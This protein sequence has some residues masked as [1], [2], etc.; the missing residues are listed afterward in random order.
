MIKK[1]SISEL[2]TGMY[3]LLYNHTRDLQDAPLCQWE[4]EVT[5]Q[6]QLQSI[7]ALELE[8]IYIDTERGAEIDS[9]FLTKAPKPLV[10]ISEK[11]LNTE[12]HYVTAPLLNDLTKAATA[13]QEAMQL[14]TGIM[15]DVRMDRPVDLKK[16]DPVIAKLAGSISK[17]KDA[18]LGVTRIR[19][20]DQY[21]VGHSVNVSILLMIYTMSLAVDAEEIR[22]VGI[23]GLLQDIGKAMIPDQILNKPAKLNIEERMIMQ[24]H[25]QHS[26]RILAN[27]PGISKISQHVIA[28]HHE[29]RDGSGY[30]NQIDNSKISL[31]GQM[32]GI[33]D[34]YDALT[35]ERP[36]EQS[37]SPH[38]ALNQL[39]ARGHHFNQDLVHKFI[40]CVG[41][42]PVG[43]LVALSNGCFGVVVKQSKHGLLLPVVRIIFDS[44]KRQYVTSEDYDLS[45]QTGKTTLE[46]IGAIEPGKWRIQ[47]EDFLDSAQL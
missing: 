34:V 12:A 46:I 32:A 21:T 17:D 27:T 1:I 35:A 19:K 2:T 6:E 30:P 5:T 26:Q 4:F 11:P 31:H 39:M 43:S 33:V 20:V 44:I 10:N 3:V 23:G 15:E 8:E 7:K 13:R 14:L 38:K 41:I 45:N 25:V 40:H 22:A 18:M 37:I 36:Y 16:V 42:Y 24:E 47:P 28:E 9:S 29:R